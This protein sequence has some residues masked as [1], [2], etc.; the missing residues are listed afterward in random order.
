MQKCAK[1][2]HT[3]TTFKTLSL[4][5]ASK[6]NNVQV[7]QKT[8]TYN[9]RA[10][11]LPPL[12]FYTLQLNILPQSC[13]SIYRSDTPTRFSSSISQSITYIIHKKAIA[14]HPIRI[15]CFSNRHH[16][17]P[18]RLILSQYNK[19]SSTQHDAHRI[20]SKKTHLIQPILMLFFNNIDVFL[21][22]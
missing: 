1:E 21:D 6:V 3:P 18:K 17:A 14:G 11:N 5:N 9:L 12:G 19:T 22:F 13:S 2:L 8:L 15:L 10:I 16:T 20:S 4:F 7:K